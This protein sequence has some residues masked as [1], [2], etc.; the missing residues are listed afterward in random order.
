MQII[1]P[2][3]NPSLTLPSLYDWAK[4]DYQ[5]E[6]CPV[7]DASAASRCQADRV[8][9]LAVKAIVFAGLVYALYLIGG[10]GWSILRSAIP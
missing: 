3:G 7:G 5:K 4:F 10:F 9:D 1:N 2:T 6:Y 8:F